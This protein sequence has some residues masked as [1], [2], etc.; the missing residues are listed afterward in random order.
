MNRTIA[1][2]F[3]NEFF[4]VGLLLNTV[5]FN[6]ILYIFNWSK[7]R[8]DSNNSEL[9]IGSFIF[10]GRNIAPAFGNADFNL[11][12]HIGFHVA[13]NQFSI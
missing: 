13:D 11:E 1:V 6:R 10:I 12:F 4:I 8:V 2:N 7:D 5:I 3:D 9:L